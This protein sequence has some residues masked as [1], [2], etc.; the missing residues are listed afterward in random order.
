MEVLY[1]PI[2]LWMIP[3]TKCL[4][5][6]SHASKRLHHMRNELGAIIIVRKTL[7]TKTDIKASAMSLAVMYFNGMASTYLMHR[8][9]IMK[10]NLWPLAEGGWIGPMTSIAMIF[11]GQDLRLLTCNGAESLLTHLLANMTVSIMR[12]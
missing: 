1:Y 3:R 10:M 2:Q 8:F 5:N 6:R 9:T 11:H 7:P 12:S 4:G